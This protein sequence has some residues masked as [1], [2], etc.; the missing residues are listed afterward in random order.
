MRISSSIARHSLLEVV[1]CVC[2][3]F[4]AGCSHENRSE[5]RFKDQFPSHVEQWTPVR[6]PFDFSTTDGNPFDPDE[7]D[8]ELKL[9]APDGSKVSHPAFFMRDY[10]VVFDHGREV[11][12]DTGRQHWEIRWTPTQSGTYEW[13]LVAKSGVSR[14]QLAGKTVCTPTQKPGFVKISSTDPQYFEFS[15]GAFFYPLG[16]VIRSPSDARW[17][18]NKPENQKV[19]LSL[20]EQRTF[21]YERWFEQ[22]EANHENFCSLWMT[23]WWLGTEWSSTYPGYEGLG[24]YNQIHAAQLDR[25]IAAAER[26]GIYILLFVTNHGQ[27]SSVTDAEW[28]TSPYRKEN[29]GPVEYPAQFMTDPQCERKTQHRLRYILARWG[30]SPAI[31]GISISTETDWFDLYNGKQCDQAEEFINGISY[32]N[33]S[34]PKNTRAVNSWLQRTADYIRSVDIHDHLVTTQFSMPENGHDLWKNP[35]FDIPLNNCYENGFPIFYKYVESSGG[36][37]EAL[38]GWARL[39][40]VPTKPKL[41]AEWGGSHMQNTSDRL[42]VDLHTGLWSIAMTDCGGTTGYWWWNEIDDRNQYGEFRALH[43][44]LD[45]Y[46]RRGKKLKSEQGHVSKKLGLSDGP[47]FVSHPTRSALVLSNE[48]EL[49][50]YVYH[51]LMNSGLINPESPDDPRFEL[52][53]DVF[54]EVPERI[55]GGQYKLEFW[56]TSRGEVIETR[57][58]VLDEP[59]T[60]PRYLEMIPLRI[61]V[62]IKL[63]RKSNE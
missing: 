31:C 18:D 45:G 52:S 48:T 23:P 14:S 38:F 3:V 12:R 30:Y 29:G 2:S 11:A 62:A 17:R 7:I 50:A 39:H 20:L 58:V 33:Y 37:A 57:E 42:A 34:I 43:K 10:D 47:Q 59:S 41:L 53:T 5:I 16:H 28:G 4:A 49:F 56:N 54:L 61:D 51:R 55:L 19:H 46:D 63:I 35:A 1:V 6:I 9:V 24:R 32:P 40:D 25:I 13:E 27:L 15:N 60:N 26:H 21:A 44:Y 8:V 36:T 22:M